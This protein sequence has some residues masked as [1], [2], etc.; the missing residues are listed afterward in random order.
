MFLSTARKRKKDA[1]VEYLQKRMY[2]EKE[3]KERELKLEERCLALEERRLALEE[4]RQALEREREQC[5]AEERD[6]HRQ[7]IENQRENFLKILDV[8]SSKEIK[9]PEC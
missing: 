9:V 1:D 8:I 7:L 3:L 5:S 4:D 6:R 2:I